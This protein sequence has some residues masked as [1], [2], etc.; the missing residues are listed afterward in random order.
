MQ[1]VMDN[2]LILT[3]HALMSCFLQNSCRL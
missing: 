2:K 3:A 1:T